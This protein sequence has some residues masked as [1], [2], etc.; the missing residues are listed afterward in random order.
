MMCDTSKEINS[1]Y[2]KNTRYSKETRTN[3][4]VI[5]SENKCKI[6]K[7]YEKQ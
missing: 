2:R 3:E 5:S 7:C 1:Y 6:G 4:L